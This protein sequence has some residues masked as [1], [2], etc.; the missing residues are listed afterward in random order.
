M[1][2]TINPGITFS[3]PSTSFGTGDCIDSHARVHA[4]PADNTIWGSSNVSSPNKIFYIGRLWDLLDTIQRKILVSLTALP[5]LG[6][7]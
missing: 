6:K 4:P 1:T 3:I 2:L 5:I 7:R